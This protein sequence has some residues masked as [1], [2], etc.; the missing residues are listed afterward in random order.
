ML[1]C[2]SNPVVSIGPILAVPAIREAIAE[3]SAPVVAVSPIIGGAAVKG[4][5]A[6]LMRG[7]GSEVSA[8]GVARLYR[9]IADGLV[10]DRKDAGQVDDVEALGLECRAV[11]TLMVDL[12]VSAELAR[13]AL[14][15][16]ESLR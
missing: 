11:D 1:V 10:I 14:E 2:P 9:E 6:Q 15:L 5:A 7:T 12:E 4:P 13:T 8:R 3:S 16:A